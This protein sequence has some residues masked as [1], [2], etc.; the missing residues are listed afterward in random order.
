MNPVGFLLFS[1]RCCLFLH[2]KLGLVVV[3][4]V[5]QSVKCLPLNPGD[6]NL[7]LKPRIKTGYV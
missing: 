5:A 7:D 4:G 6:W 1:S 3:V 2:I